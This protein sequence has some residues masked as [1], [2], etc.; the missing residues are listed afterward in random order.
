MSYS[1]L[2]RAMHVKTSRGI[3]PMVEIGD[4]NV[5]EAGCQRRARSWYNLH[6]DNKVLFKD[7]EAINAAIETWNES[8]HK[9]QEEHRNSDV[10][11][12]RET[13]E[14]NF[15]YFQSLA[16]Y[17]KS[18]WKTTFN[19][20]RNL[21]KSGMKYMLTIEEAIAS[22]QLYITGDW[23]GGRQKPNILIENEEML[24]DALDNKKWIIFQW[25]DALY[26]KQKAIYQMGHPRKG[27]NTYIVYMKGDDNK[28]HYISMNDDRT[29]F[30]LVDTESEAMGFTY[31][32]VNKWWLFNQFFKCK[33]LGYHYINV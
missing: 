18:T 25:V 24:F 22:K 23:E 8:Y 6:V 10:D 32:G 5:W 15:G 28:V 13:A 12:K 4:N 16:V 20:V 11:W 19:D 17:G 30:I 9:Q 2:Y 7:W 33:E 14:N 21:I 31:K 3:L 27:N 26:D 1:I 29:K